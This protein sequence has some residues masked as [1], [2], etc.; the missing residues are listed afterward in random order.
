MIGRV[1]ITFLLIAFCLCAIGQENA[2][3]TDEILLKNDHVLRAK[4]IEWRYGEQ[5][6]LELE[7]GGKVLIPEKII[8]T[9]KSNGLV[10]YHS[11]S[12][13]Y[14]ER[15]MAYCFSS[16]L[17][18]PSS[19]HEDG[20]GLGW[21]LSFSGSWQQHRLLNLGIGFGFDS[22]QMDNV[23]RYLPVFVELRSYLTPSKTSFYID[24]KAGRSAII[25]DEKEGS[26]DLQGGWMFYSSIGLRFSMG[27]SDL[28]IDYG[29]KFQKAQSEWVI[30]DRGGIRTVQ[31][32]T[33][34]RF[35]LRCSILI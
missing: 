5:V 23:E 4:I 27:E 26:A 17:I 7:S 28:L 35:A 8:D 12:Y 31:E 34:R 22:Y 1:L 32:F 6:Q 25:S 9:L 3:Y 21:G 2:Q 15:K 33:L 14:A 30:D 13:H 11:P 10:I 20:L 16:S 19:D 18:S 24:I 29:C